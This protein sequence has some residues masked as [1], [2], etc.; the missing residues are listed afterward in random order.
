M[1][2]SKNNRL[3]GAISHRLCWTMERKTQRA[4]CNV[5]LELSRAVY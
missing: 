4:S 1:I 3:E 2:L 5:I